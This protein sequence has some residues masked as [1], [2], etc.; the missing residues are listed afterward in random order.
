[1]ESPGKGVGAGG[2]CLVC[3]GDRHRHG[4]GP[5]PRQWA[6]GATSSPHGGPRSSSGLTAQPSLRA[7]AE[8]TAAASSR[9]PPDGRHP[10]RSAGWE[11]PCPSPEREMLLGLR[12][13]RG[14]GLTR[15]WVQVGQFQ[16][17]TLGRSPTSRALHVQAIV[18]KPSPTGE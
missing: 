18:G 3:D 9:G 15:T 1:M 16:L 4:G 12:R 10:A 11:L 17:G 5:H 2:A 8:G 13:R 14:P 7:S 6:P